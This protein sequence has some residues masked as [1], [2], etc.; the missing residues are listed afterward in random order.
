MSIPERLGTIP[1][2][3]MGYVKRTG[4]VSKNRHRMTRGLTTSDP[5]VKHSLAGLTPVLERFKERLRLLD[6]A[7]QKAE[8]TKQTT[9]E[10][11]IENK[12]QATSALLEKYSMNVISK[13]SGK[14][15]FN[16]TVRK[17]NQP[18]VLERYYM[19]KEKAIPTPI[20]PISPSQELPPSRERGQLLV[21]GTLP[22]K[23]RPR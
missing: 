12:E 1:E 4:T 7:I 18:G 20:S 19:K 21:P 2:I 11:R 14:R 15:Q 10:D 6:N 13:L 23:R 9:I 22:P 3:T 5:T 8:N 17:D 16:P